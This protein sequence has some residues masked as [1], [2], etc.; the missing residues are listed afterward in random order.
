MD[1][2][3]YSYLWKEKKD[4]YVVVSTKSGYGIA[5]QVK[6]SIVIINNPKLAAALAQEMIKNGSKVYSS[7]IAAFKDA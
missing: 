4:G 6:K 1:L 3:R 5:N 2:N 7:V